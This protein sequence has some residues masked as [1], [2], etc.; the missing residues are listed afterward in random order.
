[1]LDFDRC[2]ATPAAMP[3]V[4]AYTCSSQRELRRKRAKIQQNAM[5][6]SIIHREKQRR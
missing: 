1:M 5:D 4:L 3:L 2:I 6:R